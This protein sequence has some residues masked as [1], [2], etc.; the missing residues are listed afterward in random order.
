M[1]Y[2]LTLLFLGGMP[3]CWASPYIPADT[4]T[5]DADYL[6]LAADYEARNEPAKAI[7]YYELVGI[8]YNTNENYAGLAYVLNRIAALYISD[9]ATYSIAQVCL[10]SA[11]V[12]LQEHLPK[13]DTLH[14]A[15]WTTKAEIAFKQR[16]FDEAIKCYQKSLEYKLA[17]YGENT[18]EV[19]H[20][21]EQIGSVYLYDLQNPHE[22]ERYHTQALEI[23]EA[24]AYQSPAYINCL[25][26]LTYSSRLRGDFVKA[27][28]YGSRVLEDYKHLANPNPYNVVLATGALGGIYLSLDSIEKALDYN[29]EAIDLAAREN[30][31][32]SMDM[33][34][35]YNNHAEYHFQHKAYDSTI[36]YTRLAIANK[37][38]PEFLAVSYQLMGKAYVK[39]GLLDK[40]FQ[41]FQT[42]REIK[43]AI[44]DSQHTQLAILYLDIGKAFEDAQQADSA[45]YYYKKS[46]A[47]AKISQEVDGLDFDLSIQ[48]GDDL[49]SM[50]EGLDNLT[51]LLVN[52]YHHTGNLQYLVQAQPFFHH[53]D[54]FMDLSRA[55][56]STESA[57]LILSG[58]HKSNYEQAI[59]SSY[60]L[61]QSTQEDSLLQWIFRF[62]EKS[63]AMVLLESIH[64]AERFQQALPDSL[65]QL[66]QS[67]RS[68]LAYLQSEI[69]N[70]EQQD[71]AVS[72]VSKWQIQRASTLRKIDTLNEYIQENYPGYY[73]LTQRDLTIDIDSLQMRL[74]GGQATISYFWGDSAVYALLITSDMVKAHQIK[75]IKTLRDAIVQYKEVLIND[76]VMA[77]SYS[78]FLKFQESAYQLYQ[79]LLEPLL[80]GIPLKHLT[81]VSD[82]DLTTIP[83]ESFVSSTI[84]TKDNVVRYKN[85]PFIIKD[86]DISYE[87]SLS[88]GFWEEQY[89]ASLPSE[90]AWNVVAFGIK[91]FDNIA[92]NRLYPRLGGAE[93]EVRYIQE[94]F[95]QASIF[96]N[97]EASET[98][99]KAY[100]PQADL[101]HIAT[102]GM[103]NLDNPF[104]SQFIFYP[105][106]K[107]DGTLNLYELYDMPLKAKVLLLSA[108]ESGI[109]KHYIGE[110]NYSLARSFVYAG[111]KSVVMSL[112]QVNDIITEQMIKNI[113]DQLAQ[114]QSIS[115][116]LR[117][118][119][120]AFIE[121][122]TYAHPKCWA[123]MVPL[124][125]ASVR[126]P[127]PPYTNYATIS[128]ALIITGLLFWLVRWRHTFF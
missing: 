61:Y 3:I 78:N 113:Y 55:A 94:K 43:E 21:L 56:F 83:F 9:T 87:L 40:A 84:E 41:H 62:M 97:K 30:L 12:I 103:A 123:G 120:L 89:S 31:L 58:R 22:S 60:Q 46:L 59:A 38:K 104:T 29:K 33:S 115:T 19:A 7:E 74:P 16:K 86:Y 98:Q 39:K 109:G 70:A 24:E 42:S 54:Q 66:N 117:K 23:Q 18:L 73:N 96:L 68:Q 95:P 77:P 20:D 108:C 48:N 105:E 1:P 107:E 125:N 2:L 90:E 81:I 116:G 75:D 44:Y 35:L 51:N 34:L 36:Y 27:L 53:L 13:N 10:D 85:L 37:T 99:F 25:Y 15:L 127:Q 72:D 67:F 88:V 93:R 64:Q 17:F 65:V 79:I 50:Q 102:H 118:A 63:K 45:V 124:G 101:L 32:Q 71:R 47:S 57:K 49:E 14:A 11:N 112:W 4:V 119:K 92:S 52:Q 100:A 114:E 82:G 122:G 28:S 69:I 128:L 110:G 91:N 121:E 26:H 8:D 80:K 126:N 76:E 106:G 5:T 6:T 111:C